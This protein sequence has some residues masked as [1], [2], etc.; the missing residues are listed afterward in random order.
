[1]VAYIDSE[2]PSQLDTT[3]YLCRYLSRGSHELHKG[4]E[5]GAGD[6]ESSR[7]IEFKIL[8]ERS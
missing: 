5:T 4:N 8:G 7:V 2:H 1:M 6:R 3:N